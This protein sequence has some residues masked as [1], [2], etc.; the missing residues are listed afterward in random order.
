MGFFKQPPNQDLECPHRANDRQG[1][2]RKGGGKL[3]NT[4]TPPMWKSLVAYGN[5][6]K[7][8]NNSSKYLPPV[9]KK[10]FKEG[11]L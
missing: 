10:I 3:E 8:Q 2:I 7:K 11:Y 9:G 6:E 1:C 5:G 4:R